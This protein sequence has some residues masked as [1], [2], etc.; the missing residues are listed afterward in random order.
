MR[1][2]SASPRARWSNSPRPCRLKNAPTLRW[3]LLD[4]PTSV[5]EAKDIKILFER[6]RSLKCGELRFR[7]AP[8]RRS[9]RDQRPHLCDEGWRDRRRETC[10]GDQRSSAPRNDGRPRPRCGILPRGSPGAAR[11]RGRPG[12]ARARR[13]RRL[14]QRGFHASSR[15]SLRRRRRH[16][17]RPRGTHAD[18]VGFLP[19]T[20]GALLT[21]DSRRAC[22][23]PRKLSRRELATFHA[24]DGLKDW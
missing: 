6:I 5:L 3:I 1:A 19:Q 15:R 18:F 8:A 20:S 22:E 10:G 4:E 2:S 12:S 23:P 16:W 14:P 9:P 21:T 13:S 11:G 17:L 24:N 7:L